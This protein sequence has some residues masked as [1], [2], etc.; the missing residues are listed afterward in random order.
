MTLETLSLLESALDLG[1]QG[2]KELY[3]SLVNDFL[4]SLFL[5]TILLDDQVV[6]FIVLDALVDTFVVIYFLD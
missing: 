6:V 3:S 2:G 4:F 5:V 1:D